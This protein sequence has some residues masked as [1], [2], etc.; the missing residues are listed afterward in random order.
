MIAALTVASYFVIELPVRRGWIPVGARWVLY[1]LV[2]VVTVVAVLVGTDPA[3]VVRDRVRATLVRYA[4][5]EPVRG[6]GGVLG[7]PIRVGHAITASD[8]LRIVLIGD[9]MLY[10]AAPGVVAA[11]DATGE[12]GG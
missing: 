2:V 1:P 5:S 8:P 7:A 12:V 10:V 11:L 3:L 6:A 4:P 9:S